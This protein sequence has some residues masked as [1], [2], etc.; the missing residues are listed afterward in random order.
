MHNN[1]LNQLAQ[2]VNGIMA[3]KLASIHPTVIETEG[4]RERHFDIYSGLFK[5]RIIFVLGPVDD[6]MA[7]SIVSQLLFLEAANSEETIYMYI[8]SPGGSVTAGMSIYDTM[9]FIS[10]PIHTVC[11]GQAC[12][13]G[14]FLLSAGDIRSSMRSS[15]IMI[16]QPLG[17]Y[18]GQASDMQIHMLEMLRIKQYLNEV[19][20]ANC[21]KTFE[22]IEKDTDRDNFMGAVEAKEYGLIDSVL[23]FKPVKEGSKTVKRRPH[24]PMLTIGHGPI[25]ELGQE[26]PSIVEPEKPVAK[27]TV[28]KK[29][30]TPKAPK[31]PK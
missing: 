9:Q 11:I 2:S 12:S 24:I 4:N 5:N 29:P 22:Q 7:N 15:R 21:G 26:V 28:A 17:G 23:D 8:N 19:L 20:A 1:Q 3:P 25:A 6:N 16:H 30:A 10:A 14:A 27:K 13:M 18:Q 31:A